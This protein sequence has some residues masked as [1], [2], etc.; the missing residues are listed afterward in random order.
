LRNG[1]LSQSD[2]WL[3]KSDGWLSQRGVWL[4]ADQKSPK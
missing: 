2:V 1:R 3:S 4:S